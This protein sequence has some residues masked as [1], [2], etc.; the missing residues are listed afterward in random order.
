MTPLRWHLLLIN[1]SIKWFTNKTVL[2]C[3]SKDR[4]N[5]TSLGYLWCLSCRLNLGDG[6]GWPGIW[7]STLGDNCNIGD[8]KATSLN[9]HKAHEGVKLKSYRAYVDNN[10]FQHW[11]MFFLIHEKRPCRGNRGYFS[12]ATHMHIFSLDQS[13]AESWSIDQSEDRTE[14]TACGECHKFLGRDI[15]GSPS[16]RGFSEAGM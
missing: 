8:E 15:L 4:P 9:L 14:S 12:R 5:A 16:G 3:S 11:Q 2:P 7:K 10:E 6:G 1:G 13:E